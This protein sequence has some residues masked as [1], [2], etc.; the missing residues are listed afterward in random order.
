MSVAGTP[1]ES[2]TV[3]VKDVAR[4]DAQVREIS[5]AHSPDSDD[6]FMFSRWPLIRY[7]FP[8]CALPILS[9]ISRR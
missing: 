9:A 1:S 2:T 5:I 7:A 4:G 3:E 6:A 8:G